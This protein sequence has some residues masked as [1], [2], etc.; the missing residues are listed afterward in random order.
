[1]AE[2]IETNEPR[3]TRRIAAYRLAAR[4]LRASPLSVEALWHAD[5]YCGLTRI[6][7]VT[8]AIA[9]VLDDLIASKRIVLPPH[10]VSGQGAD[11]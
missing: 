10:D 4:G 9:R 1:L 3:L 11:G 8:P 5:G 6:E 7:H 2:Q